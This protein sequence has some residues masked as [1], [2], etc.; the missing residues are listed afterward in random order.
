[1][2]EVMIDE[3]LRAATIAHCKA[4]GVNYE[5]MKG[6]VTEPMRQAIQA[7]LAALP[8]PDYSSFQEWA[9]KH[10]MYSSADSS[11]KR[12]DEKL[13]NAALNSRA[14]QPEP[15][16]VSEAVKM[17]ELALYEAEVSVGQTDKFALFDNT[18]ERVKEAL[19]ALA[20]SK[21]PAESEG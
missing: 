20:P 11:Q 1:M 19:E 21:A 17:L 10:R 8:E 13:W 12:R 6:I 14:A 9:E 16:E 2:S 5:T 4:T 7:Y 18:L 15:V 3:P